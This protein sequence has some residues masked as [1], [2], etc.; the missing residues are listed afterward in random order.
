LKHDDDDDDDDNDDD[1][2]DDDDNKS[3][4]SCIFVPTLLVI[5]IKIISLSQQQ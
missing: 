1:D 2:D 4:Y 5:T 3:N